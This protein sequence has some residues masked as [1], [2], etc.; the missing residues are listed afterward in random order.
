M[1]SVIRLCGR[2]LWWTSSEQVL[3]RT[4]RMGEILRG[5]SDV[6]K[7]PERRAEGGQL[8][9]PASSTYTGN[10]VSAY[11]TERSF[12]WIRFNRTRAGRAALVLWCK[13][14]CKSNKCARLSGMP[15]TS[16]TNLPSGD[17]QGE[18][19]CPRWVGSAP[20]LH[21]PLWNPL[22]RP[23][24]SSLCIRCR[25]LTHIKVEPCGS[26]VPSVTGKLPLLQAS[27]PCPHSCL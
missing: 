19:V 15:H 9:R 14:L 23:A 3:L 22:P 18:N 13:T 27:P 10:Q 6:T 8:C 21:N 5:R 2:S 12:G 11:G 1:L 17:S 20:A 16:C 24:P 4:W 26:Y 25:A 7:M